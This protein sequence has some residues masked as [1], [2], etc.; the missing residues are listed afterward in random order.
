MYTALAIIL[1]MTAA[2]RMHGI[3][4][5]KDASAF[6]KA[7]SRQC[8]WV[9][10]VIVG[11]CFTYAAFK[12]FGAWYAPLGLIAPAAFTL[13]HG[14]FFE[15]KG[16]NLNDPNPE[17]I[18]R[19]GALWVWRK[20]GRDVQTPAYSQFCFAIKGALI[21]LPLGFAAPLGAVVWPTVYHYSWK[22][23]KTSAVAE[24]VTMGIMGI[25]IAIIGA[26]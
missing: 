20:L 7:V 23:F 8:K 10:R 21:A 24:Y 2:G 5:E 13:G 9:S 22:W 17:D 4:T 26:T 6:L 25:L 19:F 15:M 11:I 1:A 14:R 16:A 12:L 18:E 3:G